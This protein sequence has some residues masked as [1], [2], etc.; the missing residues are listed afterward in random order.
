MSKGVC[1]STVSFSVLVNGIPGQLF[2]PSRGIRQGDPL[3]PY[4][5]ILCAELL[6]RQLHAES[7]YG[8]KLVGVKLGHSGVKIPFLTFA[9]DTM[10]FAIASPESC[11]IIRKILDKYCSM[12]GQL[13]NYNKSAFHCSP[14]TD[15]AL[16]FS[17]SSILQ[18]AEARSLGT[19][20]GCP[21]IDTKVTNSTFGAIR[22]KVQVRLPKWKANS[23]SQAGRTVLIQSNLA[24]KANYQ[25]QSLSLPSSILDGLDKSYRNFYW[26]K[27]PDSKAPNSIGWDKVCKPKRNGGL[28]IRKAKVNNM[29]LQFKLLWKII[30]S[31]ENLWV[32][33]V[34]RK[35]LRSASLFYYKVKANVSW[36]W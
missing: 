25:M 16:A 29:A 13:V 18:M 15:A 17:F 31:P 21:I 32:N 36:Q 22:E 12:S 35:Y 19:Y 26:N 9:D 2:S 30:D 11:S 14:N 33:L 34:S 7:S 5:F 27:P 10:I 28:G 6:A 23:L 8:S 24:T 20:L 3:S 1:I 4:I